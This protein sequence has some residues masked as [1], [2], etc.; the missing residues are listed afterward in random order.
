MGNFVASVAS[1]LRK[2]GTVVLL[3]K[4]PTAESEKP[5][6]EQ[7][8]FFSA[9]EPWWRSALLPKRHQQRCNYNELVGD[10]SVAIDEAIGATRAILGFFL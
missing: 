6:L 8:S 9:K 3:A 4:R 5:R 7:A 10:D 2:T 1:T